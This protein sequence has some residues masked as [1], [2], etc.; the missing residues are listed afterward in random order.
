MRVFVRVAETG[1]FAEAARQL[2]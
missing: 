1:G 2:H